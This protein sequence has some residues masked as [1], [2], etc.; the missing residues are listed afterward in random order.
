MPHIHNQPDQHDMTVSAFVLRKEGGNWQCLVHMH[1][2]IDKLMQV[3]GHIE[4]TETPW[5]ALAHELGDETGYNLPDL[6]I[7]QAF[8][9]VPELGDP[10]VHPLPFLINT[11][12]VGNNHFHSDLCYGFVAKEEPTGVQ[13]DGESTDLRW[14]PIDELEKLQAK[15]LAVEDAVRIYKTLIERLPNLHRVDPT[16]FSL[17]KPIKGIVY[18]RGEPGSY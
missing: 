8:D 15:G 4:L 3:G 12:N 7:L 17:L 2:K 16:L 14:Y 9:D 11:H 1:K 13:A 10:I 6:E 5:Q 18:R